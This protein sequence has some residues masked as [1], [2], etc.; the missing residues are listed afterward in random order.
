[1]TRVRHD[2]RLSV[3]PQ[4]TKEDVAAA[5]AQ[6]FRLLI[7]NRPDGEAEG[8]PDAASLAAEAHRH[9]LA[10]IHIPVVG[11]SIDASAVDA[12]HAA[13]AAADGPVL[14]FCRSGTRSKMLWALGEASHRPLA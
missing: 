12:F 8:Q 1:M 11:T 4:L 14:A 10:F 13:I 5:A 3:A 6:G 9:G 2:E 7:C